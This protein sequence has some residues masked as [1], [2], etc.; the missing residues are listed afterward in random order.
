MRNERRLVRQSS[1]YKKIKLKLW[2]FFHYV[3]GAARH[4]YLKKA[5]V[6]VEF[7]F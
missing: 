5:D 3:E 1:N 6:L 7:Q 4:V 2:I